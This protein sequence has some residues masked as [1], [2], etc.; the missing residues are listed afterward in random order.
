MT[1]PRDYAPHF[2]TA[3][4]IILALLIVIAGISWD[5]HR[6]THDGLHEAIEPTVKDY[7]VVTEGEYKDVLTT[8]V[9]G[10]KKGAPK[11][12]FFRETCTMRVDGDTTDL[13]SVHHTETACVYADITRK[14]AIDKI[15]ADMPFVGSPGR[16][17]DVS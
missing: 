11:G 8:A 15:V 7:F 12:R 4:G 17:A 16:P 6:A 5:L 9:E 1:E 10:L 13:S 3:V 2:F 14:Q